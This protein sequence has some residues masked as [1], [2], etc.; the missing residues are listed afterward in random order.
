[1]A[2]YGSAIVVVVGGWG[3]VLDVIVGGVAKKNFVALKLL[4]LWR[5]LFECL[6]G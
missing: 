5:A 6:P 1:M 2:W 4:F 3:A